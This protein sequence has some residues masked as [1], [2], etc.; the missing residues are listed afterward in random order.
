MKNL[1]KRTMSLLLVLIMVLG[2]VPA[3]VLAAEAEPQAEGIEID[4]KEVAKAASEQD[5]WK[6]L[7]SVTTQNGYETKRVGNIVRGTAMTDSQ[8][9]AYGELRTWLDDT[10]GWTINESA[11]YFDYASGGNRLYL[12]ADDNVAWGM[13]LNTYYRNYA[14]ALDVTVPT[15]GEYELEMVISKTIKGNRDFPVDGWETTQGGYI[16]VLVNGE[17]VVD[18][19]CFEGAGVER[20]DLGTV[21]LLGGKNTIMFNDIKN[22]AGLTTATPCWHFNLCSLTAEAKQSNVEAADTISLDF[23]GAAKAASKQDFWNDFETVKTLD[24]HDTK[25]VGNIVRGT[26]MTDSQRKAY[27]EL[28]MWLDDTYG[29]T[30]NEKESYFDYA[31]GGNRLYLCADDN[32]NWGFS[33]N[34]Y[35]RN[36]ALAIDVDVPAAG[37]YNMS[38]VISKAVKGVKDFPVDGWDSTNSGTVDIFVNGELVYDEY[39]FEGSGIARS[40]LGAVLLKEGKNTIVFNSSTNYVGT[41]TATPCW[42]FNLCNVTFSKLDKEKV[43]EETS[44]EVGLVGIYLPKGTE[45]TPE[46]TYT[47]VGDDKLLRASIT[48]SGMLKLMGILPGETAVTV[49]HSDL[50]PVEIPV[51]VIAVDGTERQTIKLDFKEFARQAQQQPFWAEFATAADENT[52][53]IG[54][55]MNTDTI[56]ASQQDAYDELV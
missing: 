7:E 54:K 46:N 40:E 50:E 2:L 29:W 49:Y 19:Y 15:A 12:C 26:A 44:R 22:Y 11:S 55:I 8:R 17:V 13:S 21:Y 30:I 31:S 32:I 27:G 24:G 41:T 52:K 38:M 35:Y 28:R 23:K 6:D 4:F 37:R 9:T 34:T 1:F 51:E 42:H 43:A 5:F 14:L 18:E 20:V 33:L 47:E 36:Y 25:R 16:E 56:P 3:F 53:Y 39:S 45:I 10:Y 48:E